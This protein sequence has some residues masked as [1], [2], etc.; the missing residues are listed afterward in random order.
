MATTS[1]SETRLIP[2]NPRELY[3]LC[4]VGHFNLSKVFYLNFGNQM[5]LG[6]YTNIVDVTFNFGFINSE[7]LRLGPPYHHGSVLNFPGRGRS[8]RK[9]RFEVM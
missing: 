5:R 3:F 7:S 9:A 2:L 1:T 4:V 8:V 6:L